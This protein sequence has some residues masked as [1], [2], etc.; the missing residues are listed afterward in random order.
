MNL[1]P[2]EELL[3]RVDSINKKY[4]VYKN[5][6]PDEIRR[7]L[8]NIEKAISSSE[9][10]ESCLDNYLEDVFA[11]VKATAYLFRKAVLK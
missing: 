6:S 8:R 7:I 9:D 11:I 3:K 1:E 4:T 10:V 2:K 5:F